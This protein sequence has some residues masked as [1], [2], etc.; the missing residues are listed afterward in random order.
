MNNRDF[1]KH[2]ID[3]LPES[4]IEKIQEY[5][6]FQ[7]FNLGLF[8]NDTDY[9]SSIPGMTE[10]IKTGIDTPVSECFGTPE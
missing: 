2:E 4:V 1:L 6:V 7:R 10:S 5:I 9:L 8:E 3:V